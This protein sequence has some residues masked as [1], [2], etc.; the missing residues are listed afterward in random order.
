MIKIKEEKKPCAEN[1][2]NLQ[3]LLNSALDI[4]GDLIDDEECVLD[5]HGYCQTHGWFY[6]NPPCPNKRAKE[7]LKK[8]GRLV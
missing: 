7:L 6:K 2:N 4:L 3:E 1:A 5:H 8:C